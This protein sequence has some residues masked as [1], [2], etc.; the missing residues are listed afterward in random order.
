[1]EIKWKYVLGIFMITLFMLETVDMDAQRRTRT[2]R[3]EASTKTQESVP[4][5]QKLWYGLGIGNLGI[6]TNQF[7]FS[8]KGLAGYKFSKIFS[9]GLSG[10]FFYDSFSGSQSDFSY[11]TG[12][13]ARA[14][15]IN[16]I[17]V[18]G[19]YNL[20]SYDGY[21]TTETQVINGTLTSVVINVPRE[22]LAYPMLGAGYE[23]GYGPWTGGIMVLI[24][25]NST[26]RDR[27]TSDYLEYW[28]T[29][30]YNFLQ[31]Y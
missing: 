24:N 18:H 19:E 8:M 14:K 9:A 5:N 21:T 3:G 16:G 15:I 10:K 29:F 23:S 26:V 20:T 6:G 1:M 13:F 27:L 30:T 31:E 2:R 11:G 22:T 25:L 4:I 28:I 7:G 12:A 17:F